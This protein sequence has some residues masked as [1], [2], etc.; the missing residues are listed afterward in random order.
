M[1]GIAGILEKRG[2]PA[3]ESLVRA[4][5][6]ALA[7]RGPDGEG[8]F[9]DGPVG[10]G[11]RR[12]AI[13]DPEGGRQPIGNEDGSIQIAFNGEI[14]NYQEL[15]RDLAARGHRFATDSDTEVIVHAYEEWGT[16][17][18][19]R[20]RGMFAF[21]IWDSL[22]QR[23]FLARDR[24][25]IKPLVYSETANRFS[26]ASEIQGL[27]P[28]A[29]ARWKL[30]LEAIDIYLHF[31]YVPAPFS[32]FREV[33]KLPPAHYMIVEAD[34]RSTGPIRYWQLQLDPQTN[35]SEEEWLERLD[36]GLRESVRL[37]L[38]SDVQFGAF[39]SGGV[40]SST[41]AAYASDLLDQPLRTF[42][43]GFEESEYDER[44]Q[45]RAIAERLSTQHTEQV[46]CPRAIDILPRLVQHYGE[47]FAD[48]SAIPT[49]YVSRL[50]REHV[51]MVL[52]GDG[53]D[54]SFAG[55]RSYANIAWSHRRP[56]STFGRAKFAAG[57]LLRWMGLRPPNPT[58]G[59]TWYE[60][61]AYFRSDQRS[62][63]WNPQLQGVI[64]S[65]RHW[66]DSQLASTPQT[67][68]I[69]KF[70]HFDIH[71]YLPFDNL[72]KVDIASMSHGLEVRVPLLDHLLL[73]QVAQIPPSLKV[74]F[75]GGNGH[76]HGVSSKH[77]LR[78]NAERFFPKE[79][80]S[81]KKM[82]FEVPVRPWFRQAGSELQR[83]LQSP[84][85]QF[86]ELFSANYVHSLLNEHIAG[87]DHAWRLW[88]LVFFDEWLRQNESQSTMR[89]EPASVG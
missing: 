31:Q 10:L 88:S 85:E 68:L 63:L 5:T 74:R 75:S 82:G 8:I 77:L 41:V 60:G 23:L 69:T 1:C 11:H 48:S 6:D 26:F 15:Q 57:S 16:D 81:T 42:T 28:A 70:Q 71:N 13:I 33:R 40:D 19:H 2:V 34:G 54:E 61:T 44:S 62:Q 53:G 86:Q 29:E 12:L 83:R 78:K 30:D 18:L 59:D 50:A 76:P 21:A 4:M 9:T 55:Y 89:Q 7:H 58:P 43:I 36:A 47:P 66:F 84:S 56:A 52:S 20:L 72:A 80:M 49:W 32:A 73:E 35:L 37:H 51:K 17:C 38:R 67:D 65:T 79:W 14:Y 87:R 24:V 27:R 46:V 3:D 22:R 25:G 39:L 64:N 45:A